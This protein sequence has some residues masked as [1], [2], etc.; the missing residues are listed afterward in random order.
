MW[1][2]EQV[3][4]GKGKRQGV[5][6]GGGNMWDREETGCGIGRRESVG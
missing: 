6:K 1:D 4:C 3:I 2:R 5:G